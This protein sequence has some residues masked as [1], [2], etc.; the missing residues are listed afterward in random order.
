MLQDDHGQAAG[1]YDHRPFGQV[2]TVVLPDSGA[3]PYANATS[4]VIARFEQPRLEGT[5]TKLQ[6]MFYLVDTE[7]DQGV[8]RDYAFLASSSGTELSTQPIGGHHLGSQ[9]SEWVGVPSDGIVDVKF[10]SDATNACP[11][12]SGGLS[13][14][15]SCTQCPNFPY[16]G[17]VVAGYRYRRYQEGASPID[18]PLRFPG[19][20]QDRE[21][22]LFENWNRYY[23]PESGRY[24]QPEPKPILSAAVDGQPGHAVNASPFVYAATN[25]TE[26]IDED[27]RKVKAGKGCGKDVDELIKR[28]EE[29]LKTAPECGCKETLK[30]H[31]I[32][33]KIRSAKLSY[34]LRCHKNTIPGGG[35]GKGEGYKI[36]IAMGGDC[37]CQTMW[38]SQK[39][40]FF[41]LLVHELLH[42]EP[43]GMRHK[44]NSD[45]KDETDDVEACIACDGKVVQ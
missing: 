37:E 22:G 43:G 26:Y 30:K 27:G 45:D 13:C 41:K 38:C 42:A 14:T 34:D 24:L 17:T 8:P 32:I 3:H 11:D 10:V 6:A 40:C 29:S 31:G 7:S 21:T 15:G 33:N 5:R 35:C 39:Y 18:F 16:T 19:Q 4:G 44:H 36:D 20:Y 25:P 2:N 23:E 1:S 9:V 28:I 12:G